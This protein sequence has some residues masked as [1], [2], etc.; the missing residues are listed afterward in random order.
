[1]ARWRRAVITRQ[2]INLSFIANRLLRIYWKKIASYLKYHQCDINFVYFF[3]MN[4][5]FAHNLWVTSLFMQSEFTCFH[6][7]FCVCKHGVCLPLF[8]KIH[9]S[10]CHILYSISTSRARLSYDFSSGSFNGVYCIEYAAFNI[11]ARDNVIQQLCHVAMSKYYYYY[12]FF[13]LFSL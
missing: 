11:P 7:F 12:Y 13:S 4:S 9:H 8:P 10:Y 1:M 6:R 5:V 3:Q 2:N